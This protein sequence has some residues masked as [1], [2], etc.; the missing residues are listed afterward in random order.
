MN[1]S[2]PA[3][4]LPDSWGAL[5]RV[6]DVI[7]ADD[8]EIHRAGVATIGT[9][10]EEACGSA[11]GVEPGA[12]ERAW[13]ELL[14]RIC[15][16]EAARGES[17]SYR[18]RSDGG[19]VVGSMASDR[20]FPQSDAPER[21]RYARSNGVAIHRDWKS[22]CD[23]ARW[24]LAERDRVVRSW[25]GEILPRRLATELIPRSV[26]RATSY[27]WRAYSFSDEQADGF[28]DDVEVVG[29]FGL[30]TRDGVPFVLGLAA[31]PNLGDA[32]EA[33][34]SE[35]LQMLAFLWGE[36]PP[37]DLAAV[38]P[39]AAQHLDRYQVR[40]AHELV[41]EWLDDGHARYWTSERERRRTAAP[42]EYVDL[43][44]P[45]LGDGLRVAKASCLDAVPLAF[46][47]S[48][49]TAHLPKQLRLHPIP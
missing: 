30:P 34:A 21:W 8:V 37:T 18:L 14:E 32:V 39:G 16:L 27:D 20:V 1:T 46:G 43:T 26:I 17:A 36:E 25:L 49:L 38:P 19:D 7:V 13:Y 15:T 31:R 45:W 24:E 11:A 33:A 4:R 10:G 40:G 2:S 5:E 41:R 3:F 35:S 12:A 23:R 29:V 42:V 22:A 9:G 6:E 44:P 48:P 47:D 28:A